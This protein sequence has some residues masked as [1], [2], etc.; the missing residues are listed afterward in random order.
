MARS[1]VETV[2]HVHEHA[3]ATL[4]GATCTAYTTHT[5]NLADS[6]YTTN[7]AAGAAAAAEDARRGSTSSSRRPVEPTRSSSAGD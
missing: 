3:E 6:T 5:T 7:A 2:V 1:R 4:A